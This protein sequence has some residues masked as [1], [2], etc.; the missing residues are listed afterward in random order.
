MFKIA[1]I[2]RC[3]CLLLTIAT[4]QANA[5]ESGPNWGKDSK[6]TA[7]DK[8]CEKQPDKCI[9]YSEK[10]LGLDSNSCSTA[11]RDYQDKLTEFSEACGAA[12]FSNDSLG[13]GEGNNKACGAEMMKCRCL[14]KNLGSATKEAYG[15]E[16]LVTPDTSGKGPDTRAAEQRFRLCPGT[17]SKG[18]KDYED[19]LDKSDDRVKE[20][21]DKVTKLQGEAPKAQAEA[22]QKQDDYADT[23]REAQEKYSEDSEKAQEGLKDEQRKLME[24]YSKLQAEVLQIEEQIGQIELTKLDAAMKRDEFKKQVRMNCHVQAQN[25]IGR[26]QAEA[27]ELRRQG[28]LNVGGFNNLMNKAGLTDRQ[29]WQQMADK[30]YQWCMQSQ[31][32]KESMDT[33]NVSYDA[34]ITQ[35]KKAQDDGRKRMALLN[36]QM[37]QLKDPS[38]A[39]GQVFTLAAADGSPNQSAMCQALTQHAQK[40]ARLKAA[41]D[42]RMAMLSQQAQTAQKLANATAL[43]KQG[44]LDKAKADL[45]DEKERQA[46]MRRYIDLARNAGGS[47]DAEKA[48]FNK[49]Q[50]KFLAFNEAAKSLV[51]CTGKISCTRDRNP[52]CEEAKKYVENILKE[53]TFNKPSA[54]EGPSPSLAPAD[55]TPR[56]TSPTT[57]RTRSG[58]DAGR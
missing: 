27:L 57:P 1:T 7:L 34:A 16:E 2:V 50:G 11:S 47:E 31:P 56:S 38:G 29:H 30:Y 49:A 20:L 42:S 32:T 23:A 21:D 12:N 37:K 58:S 51:N 9:E 40:Q 4:V 33:A 24:Q 13:Q 45:A 5:A 3:F 28:K 52:Q 36:E 15:C 35:A 55:T 46:R 39:C 18:L 53:P 22:Q 10:I 41:Y 25:T 8:I 54:P 19:K 26:L 17:A 14:T 43:A 44:E 48:A 6:S